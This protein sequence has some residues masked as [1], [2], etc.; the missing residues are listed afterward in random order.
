MQSD[1]RKSHFTVK[2]KNSLKK[3]YE[4]FFTQEESSETKNKTPPISSSIPEQ[5]KTSK[6]NADDDGY[7]YY[8]ED[9]DP[10]STK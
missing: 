3:D 1:F 9:G 7:E 2:D 10:S 5:I 4:D 8:D 6:S